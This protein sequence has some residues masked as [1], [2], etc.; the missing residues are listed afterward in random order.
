MEEREKAID[1]LLW[2][3]ADPHQPVPILRWSSETDETD[4]ESHY[5]AVQT[6]VHF[7]K[8]SVLP[9]LKPDP[10]RD[11]FSDLWAYVGDA[12]SVDHLA[13]ASPPEDWSPAILHCIREKAFDFAGR[14]GQRDWRARHCLERIGKPHGGMLTSIAPDEIRYLR[15][16]ILKM[17]DSYDFT[18][19]IEWL[20]NPRH[21]SRPIYTEIMRTPAMQARITSLGI[22]EK[23]CRPPSRESQTMS[24]APA[25]PASG[26][27]SSS[28]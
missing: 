25:L 3:G 2:T 13:A 20:G 10:K 17:R 23:R 19:L 6:A 24:R 11:N 16:S 28:R 15:G 26:L 8:G 1:V 18:W 4:S 5:S 21:C 9:L 7:G 12:E 27:T 14:L 22:R